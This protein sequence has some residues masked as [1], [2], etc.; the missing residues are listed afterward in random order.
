MKPIQQFQGK[1]QIQFPDFLKLDLRVGKVLK[2]ESV[3]GSVN[4]IR[5][6]VD[7][8]SDYGVRTIFAGMARWYTPRQLTGKKFVFVANLAPKK[9]MGE[10]SN[11]MM[12]AADME[13]TPILI[14]LNKKIKE[15]AVVR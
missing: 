12:M 4:L 14:P 2:A 7:L 9:M 15:G 5:M 1:E 11:G 3:E 13:G 10:E 6:S 8:G